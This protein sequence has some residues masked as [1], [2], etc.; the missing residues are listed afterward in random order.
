MLPIL[1]TKGIITILSVL[2]SALVCAFTAG[3]FRGRWQRK[4]TNAFY[5][6]G[7]ATECAVC[8]CDL[9]GPLEILA[10]RHIFHRECIKD[11]FAGSNWSCPLDRRL[12]GG[13][14]KQTYEYR[15]EI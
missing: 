13:I 7:D 1:W 12:I 6:P 4:S 3:Y 2:L 10:C 11:W 9:S 8:L 15:F 14:E 5:C